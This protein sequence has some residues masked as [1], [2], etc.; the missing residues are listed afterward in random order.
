METQQDSAG[1]QERRAA[2]TEPG[3]GTGGERD[4]V[5]R[6]VRMEAVGVVDLG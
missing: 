4:Y 6:P 1:I 5:G 3:E 2:E